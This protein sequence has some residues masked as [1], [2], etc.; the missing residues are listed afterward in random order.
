MKTSELT[1]RIKIPKGR[2]YYLEFKRYITPDKTV[3]GEK[4]F[5]DYSPEDVRKVEAI[6][7]Y[8]SQ[9]FKYKPAYQRALVDLENGETVKTGN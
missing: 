3:V 8:L 1:A 6:W 9:G 2:L 4:E 7:K 5:R